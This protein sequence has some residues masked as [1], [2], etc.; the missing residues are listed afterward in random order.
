MILQPLVKSPEATELFSMPDTKRKIMLGDP[1]KLDSSVHAVVVAAHNAVGDGRTKIAALVGDKTRNDVQRHAAARTV[2]ERA[3]GVLESAQK[4]LSA[5]ARRMNQDATDTVNQSF[6][7]DPNRASIQSEIR[8]WIRE[9]AKSVEGLAKI[10]EA[11]K[12]SAEVGAILF[13]SPHFLLGLADSVRTSMMMD[14][15]E[16]HLPKAHAMFEAGIALEGAAAKYPAAMATVRRTFFNPALADQ[17][18]TRVEV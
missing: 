6:A 9:Q 8:G 4:Q 7:A 2:A 13:H 18:K 3:I 16:K 14:A 1:D 11:M 15:I 12:A 5:Q 10:R 17:A